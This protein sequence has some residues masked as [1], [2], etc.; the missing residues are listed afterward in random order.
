MVPCLCVHSLHL[1]VYS[2]AGCLFAVI[3]GHLIFDRNTTSQPVSHV[4]SKELGEG[5]PGLGAVL[6]VTLGCSLETKVA[7]RIIKRCRKAHEV[8][9]VEGSL[10]AVRTTGFL[11]GKSQLLASTASL[12]SPSPFPRVGKVSLAFAGTT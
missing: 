7:A 8:V 10:G 4:P 9:T 3:T 2:K 12:L 11:L 6:R 1:G 5:L